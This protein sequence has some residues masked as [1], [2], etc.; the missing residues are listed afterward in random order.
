ML[1]SYIIA[2]LVVC[3][4]MVAAGAIVDAVRAGGSTGTVAHRASRAVHAR[5]SRSTLSSASRGGH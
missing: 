1:A 3:V 5:T 2:L 4:S